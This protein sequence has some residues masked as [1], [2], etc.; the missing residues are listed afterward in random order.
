MKKYIFS[1]LVTGF[2]S[3]NAS[4]Q[5]DPWWTK[6]IMSVNWEIGVPLMSNYLSS[7]SV[8]GANLEFKHFI[9]DKFSLGMGLHW[10]TFEQYLSPRVYEVPDGSRAV[11]TDLVPQVFVLPILL[12]GH[13]YF[14]AGN[15]IKPYAGLGLGAQFSR[16]RIYYNVFVDDN[17]DWGF[18]TRP[19]VGVMYQFKYGHGGLNFN[20][21]FNYAT[22][23]N[24]NFRVYH[25]KHLSFS[26]GG[27]W[28]LY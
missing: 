6:N 17:S 7:A 28:N 12:K 25:L 4:A 13:Y 23:N 26:I 20:T 9:K 1:L 5:S 19:E 15:N 21:A 10:N 3:F 18:A 8:A 11:F 24:P 14:D 16:Q 22:N 2:I 27:W